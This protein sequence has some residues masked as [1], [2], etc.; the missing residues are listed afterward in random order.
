M[1]NRTLRSRTVELNQDGVEFRAGES[2]GDRASG[3]PEL[4]GRADEHLEG[5]ETITRQVP[6][7]ESLDLEVTETNLGQLDIVEV[8]W[9]SPPEISKADSND[10]RNLFAKMLSA[11]KNSSRQMQESNVEEN[12]KALQNNVAASNSKRQESARADIQS[13]TEKLIKRFE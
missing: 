4:L 7:S 9:E 5:P 3:Q 12:N 8:R 2:D 13:E 11:I 1:A 10:L 6:E